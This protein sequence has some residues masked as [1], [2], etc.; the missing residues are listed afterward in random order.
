M[1][2]TLNVTSQTITALSYHPDPQLRCHAELCFLDWISSWQLYPGQECR[3]TWFLSWSPCPNCAWHVATFLKSNRHVHLNIFA[4]RIYDYQAGYEEGLCSLWDAGAHISI[5]TYEDFVYCWR[6][7]VNS[8]LRRFIPWPNLKENSQIISERLEGILREGYH[9]DPQL[10]CHAELCFLDWISS[11]QLYPGQECRVTWFLSWSPCP[12]CAWHVA[13]F[14]KSNRHVHLNI[15]AARIYDYQAGYEEGLCSLWDAGAHI[16]VMTYEDFEYCWRAFVNNNLRHF[17]PWYK[18]EENRQIISERL[19]R[20]LWDRGFPDTCHAELLCL[21][22]WS[23]S[24]L[25]P[26]ERY[27][28][29]W[30]LSRIPCFKCAVQVAMFLESHNEISL[31]IFAAYPYYFHCPEIHIG[32]HRLWRAKA[33]IKIMSQE[34]FENCWMSFVNHQGTSLQPWSHLVKNYE[35]WTTKL[36]DI[37][38]NT[39][40]LLTRDI[41]YTQFNN[42]NKI[43]QRHPPRDAYLCYQLNGPQCVKC[44]FRYKSGV[45]CYLSSPEYPPQSFPSLGLCRHC[46]PL[47]SALPGSLTVNSCFRF[48]LNHSLTESLKDFGDHLEPPTHNHGGKELCPLPRILTC[49]L[50]S[51]MGTIFRQPDGQVSR[52]EHQKVFGTVGTGSQG[53]ELWGPPQKVYYAVTRFISEICSMKLEEDKNYNITCYL[54]WSPC[55]RGAKSLVEFMKH[56][57]QLKLTIFTSR[58]YYFWERDYK[59]GLRLLQKSNIKVAAMTESGMAAC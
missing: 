31:S 46:F 9:P 5:M 24:Q 26:K 39:M 12:N 56:K 7:F 54:T 52:G 10:R 47:N 17:S 33:Q 43:K 30:Y 37:H 49:P 16:S 40:D 1:V 44:C 19:Q 8:N 58:L 29:I 4:A 55:L 45:L 27:Q 42:K 2:K 51:P 59:K 32:L 23:S 3:V 34:D 6:T 15:F 48:Q 36:N 21:R 38:S 50:R 57:P 14:L 28:V 13:T 11:W 41:F 25:P 53:S 18:L 22:W 20:I 35:Q